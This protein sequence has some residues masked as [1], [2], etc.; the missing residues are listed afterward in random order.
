[1]F[2]KEEV[3]EVGAET[4]K[5]VD[6]E[7]EECHII[8]INVANDAV[9]MGDDTGVGVAPFY[10]VEIPSSVNLEMLIRVGR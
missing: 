9:T 4:A 7:W 6:G 5:G 3:V 2:V 1:M 10:L 8:I